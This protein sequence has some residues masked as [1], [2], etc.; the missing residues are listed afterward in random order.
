MQSPE[1][2]NRAASDVVMPLLS[3]EAFQTW[4]ATPA[5]LSISGAMAAVAVPEGVDRMAVAQALG[6]ALNEATEFLVDDPPYWL[7]VSLAPTTRIDW[8]RRMDAI[9][10]HSGP[11]LAWGIDLASEGRSWLM[12]RDEALRQLQDAQ[13]QATAGAKNKRRRSRPTR[14]QYREWQAHLDREWDMVNVVARHVAT[15]LKRYGATFRTLCPFHPEKT[16]SFVIYPGPKIAGGHAYCYGCHVS[17]DPIAFIRQIEGVGYAEAV[18]IG[19]K[20][21]GWDPVP[22]ARALVWHPDTWGEWKTPAGVIEVYRDFWQQLDLTPAHREALRQ[23]GLHDAEIDQAAF[24]S[25]P[26]DRTGW[27]R[28]L[29]RD[30]ETMTGIPGFCWKNDGTV[31]GPPGLLIPVRAWDGA[32]IGAQIRSDDGRWGSSPLARANPQNPGVNGPH[33]GGKYTWFSTPQTNPAYEGGRSSGS[34]P[35]M[36]WPHGEAPIERPAVV[37]LTEGPLKATLIANWLNVPTIGVGGIGRYNAALP[38]IDRLLPE[39]VLLAYDA[40]VWQAEAQDPKHKVALDALHA[41]V[42]HPA[43]AA[44]RVDVARWEETAG[45]GLDDVIVQGRPWTTE[46]AAPY[47]AGAD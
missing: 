37:I 4:A 34:P 46:P 12:V 42:H 22:E 6:P 17:G 28:K 7:V 20:E 3:K 13:A 33:S 1:V 47:V 35:H 29:H 11:T 45:K 9:V 39:R 2:P 38:L 5:S 24:R 21:V 43:L 31:I 30:Q 40:D 32:I 26:A 18:Q 44:D 8:T 36:A 27:W 14:E 19:L 15:P 23:R 10:S 16:P 41:L 25:M